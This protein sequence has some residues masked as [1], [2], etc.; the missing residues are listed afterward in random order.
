MRNLVSPLLIAFLF[1]AQIAQGQELT[2]APP[3]T[4]TARDLYIGCSLYI[5]DKEIAN[6][7]KVPGLAYSA[8]ACSLVAFMAYGYSRAIK[9]GNEW[10]YCVPENAAWAADPVR[11]LATA[12]VD[13]YEKF[14]V[15]NL[16]KQGLTTMLYMFKLNWPCA[17]S[18]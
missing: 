9:P 8:E 14:R 10:E 3:V 5:R 13:T 18:K 6:A 11:A 2:N 15:P 4:P 17:K 16:N 12:Y 7:T 1:Q